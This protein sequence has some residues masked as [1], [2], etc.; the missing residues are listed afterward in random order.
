MYRGEAFHG[1]R[2]SLLTSAVNL[3]TPSW[4]K[5]ATTTTGWG[6]WGV[7]WFQS[8]AFAFAAHKEQRLAYWLYVSKKR[9]IPKGIAKAGGRLLMK[10]CVKACDVV[11]G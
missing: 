11:V 5:R 6:G 2:G 3:D 9:L 1:K 8:N 10:P 4:E 7:Y